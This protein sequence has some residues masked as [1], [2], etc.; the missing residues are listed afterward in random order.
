ML[1]TVHERL[2]AFLGYFLWQR[3]FKDGCF[4]TSSS[5]CNL[6]WNVESNLKK[7]P[8]IAAHSK[9]VLILGV[10]LKKT[11]DLLRWA[12]KKKIYVTKLVLFL[13]RSQN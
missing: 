5:F 8:L 12:I 1:L 6:Y 3:N 4:R 7:K 10:S 9:Y 2:T 11:S 13:S